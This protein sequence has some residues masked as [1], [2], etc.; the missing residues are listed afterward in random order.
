MLHPDFDDQAP[1][2]HLM[3]EK[4]AQDAWFEEVDEE[5]EEMLD[6]LTSRPRRTRD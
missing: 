3:A 4:E 1:L 2:R 6:R 5:T